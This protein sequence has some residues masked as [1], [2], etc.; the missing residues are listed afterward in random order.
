[1]AIETLVKAGWNPEGMSRMFERLKKAGGELGRPQFLMSHPATD[2]RIE[3]VKA[4]IAMLPPG[5]PGRTDDN[6]QLKLIQRRLELISGSESE[7]DGVET[8]PVT[9]GNGA[10]SGPCLVL[11]AAD[12]VRRPEQ[13][14]A[15]TAEF[16]CC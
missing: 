11:V 2:E 14:L 4:A 5:E 10:L 7:S 9:S 6:G 8:T 13:I 12:G 1:L 16:D 3:N 15:R